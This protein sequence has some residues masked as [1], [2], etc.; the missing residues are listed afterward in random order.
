[1]FT[2]TFHIVL[3]SHTAKFKWGDEMCQNRGVEMCSLGGG[4]APIRG[5]EMCQIWGVEM[6]RD[7]VIHNPCIYPSHK[8]NDISN[9]SISEHF[10]THLSH[11][12]DD[13]SNQSISLLNLV[14]PLMIFQR[15][16]KLFPSH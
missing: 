7:E 1:M 2:F 9:Q 16:S 4:K 12:R 6:C 14:T 10:P 8:L 15:I 3:F 13:H 5:V 11:K